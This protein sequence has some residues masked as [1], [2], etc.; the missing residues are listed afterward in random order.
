MAAS[1]VAFNRAALFP[2]AKVLYILGFVVSFFSV[3]TLNR[4]T[5]WAAAGIVGVAF[6]L[7]LA[8][9]IWRIWITAEAPVTN[10]YGTFLFVGLV[11]VLLGLLVERRTR[12][13]LGSFVASISGAS[14]LFIAS[15][16]ELQGDTMGKMVAVLN[17]TFWLSTHVTAISMGY[18]GCFLASIMGVVYLV[19]R[20]LLPARDERVMS[21]YRVTLGV[22]AFGFTMSFLGTM[23]GGVW[24]DQSWGRF[25]GWDP[26]E[27]GALLIVLWC[28]V[29]YHCRVA[30]ICKESG[31]AAGAALGGIWV[32]LA[33]FG[34]NLLGVGL[35]SYGFTTGV[36]Y[37]L[38]A[39][40]A[41]MLLLVAGLLV[42]VR[43][44]DLL[45]S[46]E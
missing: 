17:S 19:M 12:D 23:L 37:R 38:Y 15:R 8:G 1:E 13:G 26:K 16:Y 27:N 2:N 22:L 9:E 5:R 35:H 3:I 30:G 33:W 39:Y 4:H 43:F 44:R 25:W 41:V 20:G 28:A 6:L 18:A 29:I 11:S 40:V 34:S 31:M 36:A 10:L 24:A 45:R 21:A 32:M 42:R 14:L 7:H 46:E